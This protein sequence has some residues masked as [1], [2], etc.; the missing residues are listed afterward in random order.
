MCHVFS[1]H[2]IFLLQQIVHIFCTFFCFPYKM[3]LFE[4]LIIQVMQVCMLVKQAVCKAKTPLTTPT[5]SSQYNCFLIVGQIL[6]YY[7][8]GIYIHIGNLWF[9]FCKNGIIFYYS[10]ICSPPTSPHLMYLGRVFHISSNSVVFCFFFL[11]GCIVCL[12]QRY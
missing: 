9:C 8:L 11:N 6:S 4:I 10:P 5:P 12:K 7:F 2:F 3:Y 1:V